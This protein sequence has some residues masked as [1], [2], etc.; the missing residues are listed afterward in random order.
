[1]L[2]PYSLK[3]ESSGIAEAIIEEEGIA[4]AHGS[5]LTRIKQDDG[6][7]V[8][9][10]APE[11]GRV[12]L[13]V[14]TDGAFVQPGDELVVI[15]PSVT[16]VENVLVALALVGRPEDVA[17]V[18]RYTQPLAGMPNHIREMASRAI[19]EINRRAAVAVPA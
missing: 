14:A 3:A 9:I 5:P 8:E 10:R 2:K 7:T 16:Q 11:D 17:A 13:V 18:E 1:M 15:S 4:V 19:R 6:Q 12:E